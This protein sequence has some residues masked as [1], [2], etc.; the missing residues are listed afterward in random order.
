MTIRSIKGAAG[1]SLFA[2]MLAVGASLPT[3]PASAQ[4]QP[5]TAVPRAGL[6]FSTNV[7]TRAT[8]ESVDPDTRTAAFSLPDGRLIHVSVADSVRNL[9][10]I[11]DGTNVTVTYNEIVTILNLRQKGPGSKLARSES[12]NPPTATD[13]ESGRFTLTVTA[14]DLA[15]NTI[16]VIDG[17]GGP[18]RTYTA[19]T[20]VQKEALKKAKIGDVVIGL[21]TPMAATAITPVN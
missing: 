4:G 13:L 3:V 5:L 1:A 20:P 9:D 12:G 15:S 16:S 8:I 21:T 18:I 2:A 6:A 17:R 19:T 14:V 7:T 11:P 10:S